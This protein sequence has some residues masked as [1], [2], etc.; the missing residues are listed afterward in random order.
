MTTITIP[1]LPVYPGPDAGAEA[2]ARFQAELDHY[3]AA[4]NALH[5]EAARVA[6]GAHEKLSG[7]TVSDPQPPA[8]PKPLTRADLALQFAIA[9]TKRPIPALSSA[10]SPATITSSATAHADAFIAAHPG[11]VGGA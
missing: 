3:R 8:A 10:P 2:L 1:P 9:L 7:G 4:S 11:I 5:A 6:A